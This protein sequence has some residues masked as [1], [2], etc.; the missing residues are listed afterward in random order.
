VAIVTRT[1]RGKQTVSRVTDE[2]SA[3]Q[4]IGPRSAF[5]L[6]AVTQLIGAVLLG[7]FLIAFLLAFLPWLVG[8]AATSAVEGLMRQLGFAQFR[9]D[10]VVDWLLVFG[11]G[12]AA[13]CFF[14]IVAVAIAGLA[15]FLAARVTFRRF[16]GAAVRASQKMQV[17]DRE[18]TA[19]REVTGRA[20][21]PYEQRT[22]EE[23]QSE[24]SRRGIRGRSKMKKA[25]LIQALRG[26]SGP[27]TLSV[28]PGTRETDGSGSRRSAG[29]RRRGS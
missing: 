14:V 26:R 28:R 2:L 27:G 5:D 18:P 13:V 29:S 3:A 25:E 19:P 10:N 15:N 23:L 20:S 9:A 7:L 22:L 24:A 12:L 1:P 17:D 16:R 6:R 11:I 21:R 4:V 8:K